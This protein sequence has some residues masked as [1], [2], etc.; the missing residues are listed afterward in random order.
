MDLDL[1]VIRK[2]RQRLQESGLSVEE[3][4][5]LINFIGALLA[6]ADNAIIQDESIAEQLIKTISTDIR[7]L[8]IIDRQ[9]A[10]LDALKR[11]TLNLTSSLELQTVLDAVVREAMQLV[12]NSH[13]AH[14]YLYQ[15][16]QLTFMAALNEDGVRNEQISVP[17]SDGLTTTVATRKQVVIVEDMNT[18]PLFVNA[19]KPWSGSIIGIPL[20]MGGVVVGVMNLVRSQTGPFSKSEIRLLSLLADQAAIAIS[21]ARLHQAVN[22]QARSDVLTSLPN[23]RALDE[24]LDEAIKNSRHTGH[25]FTV[26]MLD[27]DGFKFVNDTYG[28]EMGDEVLRQLADSLMQSLRSTDFLARYGGDEMTLVLPNTDLPQAAHVARKFQT[29]L[30]KLSIRLPDG[31]AAILGVSGG[32]AMYP[33][34]ADSASGL[35]RAADEALYQAK[36]HAR[37]TFVAARAMTGELKPVQPQSISK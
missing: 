33:A 21:N 10:E 1:E 28:H 35:L 31:K 37:G 27:L 9:A 18:H 7:L 26:I 15:D 17:R 20:T 30:R 12:R 19:P 29:Q 24:R 5:R 22:R 14:I 2:F 11:I 36:K 34:H 32:I 23:R 8:A 25:P 6:G 4:E 3:Q 16:D 13:E